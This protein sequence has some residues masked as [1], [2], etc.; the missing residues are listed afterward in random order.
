MSVRIDRIKHFSRKI[1]ERYN[2]K[3]KLDSQH[4]NPIS[5]E[6]SVYEVPETIM[7]GENDP[8]IQEEIGSTTEE[9]DLMNCLTSSP[10]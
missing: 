9:Y 8:S 10:A 4:E 3:K 7:A 2:F 1:G 6:P 5:T